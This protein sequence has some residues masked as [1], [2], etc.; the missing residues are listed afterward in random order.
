MTFTFDATTVWESLDLRKLI[1]AAEQLHIELAAARKTRSAHLS[2]SVS[3][4][5]ISWIDAST[6]HRTCRPARRSAV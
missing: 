6:H 5:G 1:E 3:I 2:L 4:S